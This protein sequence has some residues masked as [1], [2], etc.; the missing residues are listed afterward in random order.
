MA[1]AA[2]APMIKSIH[3]RIGSLV[4]Y[5][6]HG[7]QCVRIH[8]IPRNPDTE[9]QRAVRRVFGNAVRTWQ[10]MTEEERYIFNKKA[11]YV[12][13][14][15]YN[16]YISGYMNTNIADRAGMKIVSR[17]PDISISSSSLNSITSVSPPKKG[18]IKAG[19]RRSPL[20]L[21]PG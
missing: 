14:S 18:K 21:H 1:V 11:R 8:V 15:G 6:R 12:N 7:R 9:A 19:K 4:F 3:G 10:T 20:K 13:M 17:T 2:T 16:L 5:Y